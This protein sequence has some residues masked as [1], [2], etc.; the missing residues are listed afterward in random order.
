MITRFGATRH[1]IAAIILGLYLFPLIFLTLYGAGEMAA[2]GR[3]SLFS[4][5]LLIALGGTLILFSIWKRWEIEDVEEGI[6]ASVEVAAASIDK[7]NYM[8]GALEEYTKKE[9]HT[10]LEMQ[11]QAE[12]LATMQKKT[13]ECEQAL[14][15]MHAHWELYKQDVAQ[16]LEE[17][18]QRLETTSQTIEQHQREIEKLAEELVLSQA[19][20][21]DLKYEI[22]TLLDLANIEK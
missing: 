14:Q 15:E 2:G 4:W 22:K 12:Q 17:R 19:R 9:A 18:N 6:E 7:E 1:A 5:G 11:L 20:E 13:A 21:S 8:Q 10:A 3:W 16:Q